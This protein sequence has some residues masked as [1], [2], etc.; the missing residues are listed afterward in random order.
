MNK[1]NLEIQ[2]EFH[3]K[4]P[5][6]INE[7]NE[8]LIERDEL[9]RLVVLA[10]CSHNH[11][12]LIGE[13]G[14]AKSMTVELVNGAVSGATFWQLQVNN[15]TKIEE[16][17][18]AKKATET[19]EIQYISQNS[20]LYATFVVLDEMFKAKG[21]LLNALL[22]ILVDGCYTSGDG[23]KRRTQLISVFATSNE[24][25][26]EERMLPYVDRFL[27]WYEVERISTVENRRRFY[28]G[29]Y[30]KEKITKQYFSTEDLFLIKEESSKVEINQNII[31]FYEEITTE[32]VKQ[33]V[34]TSD[35][36]Y[37][38]TLTTAMKTCAYLNNR[39]AIDISDIFI[40]LHTSW[41]DAFEK[42]KVQ[43]VV[44]EKIFGSER[45]IE[46]ELV[47]SNV[48]IEE[49]DTYKNANLYD[50]LYYKTELTGKDRVELYD[51]VLS[52]FDSVFRAYEMTKT[53]LKQLLE[54]Y[55]FNLEVERM[56]ERNMFL[57]NYKQ[58]AFTRELVD[59]IELLIFNIETKQKA[60]K[61]WYKASDSIYKYQAIMQKR[62]AKNE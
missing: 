47:E 16:L 57:P 32:F 59:D 38:R 20:M 30:N 44:F 46:K 12:F 5:E 29:L 23:K 24:Y 52:N 43:R 49:I 48:S 55:A 28:A 34:K 26:T 41:H 19:G 6:L 3:N 8:R 42:E 25:P 56:L 40:L 10:M 60:I 45:D 18:G 51:R 1:I 22:E 4:I 13:R 17:F 9:S 33:A 61:E 39:E 36:K 50:F 54:K 27:F 11:M 31:E 2:K 35:R 21:E 14:V 15:D 37:E 7:L 58:N 62:K 53:R